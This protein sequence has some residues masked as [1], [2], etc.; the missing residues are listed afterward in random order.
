MMKDPEVRRVI[1]ILTLIGLA[2]LGLDALYM[3]TTGTF[4]CWGAT[5]S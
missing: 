5:C 2:L 3:L 4:S 1:L